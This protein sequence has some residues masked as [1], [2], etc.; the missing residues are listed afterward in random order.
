MHRPTTPR[1][2]P[3]LR[4]QVGLLEFGG[5]RRGSLRPS[6]QLAALARAVPGRPAPVAVRAGGGVRRGAGRQGPHSR[7]ADHHER[8]P[9]PLR[10]DWPPV[11][12]LHSVV[13][14][15]MGL[16]QLGPLR[17]RP[18]YSLRQHSSPV[19]GHRA[20]GRHNGGVRCRARSPQEGRQEPPSRAA[21]RSLAPAECDA[22]PGRD[23]IR[24]DA[25]T[26]SSDWL[27]LRAEP[28]GG[29][30]R[31]DADVLPEHCAAD[32]GGLAA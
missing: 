13:P 14:G 26:L 4:R 32:D 5:V 21:G 12:R 29:H 2:R 17:G 23:A 9:A 3:P 7:Q 25:A 31:T 20:Y 16:Y 18:L 6:R 28:R 24:N 22:T 27:R 11:D 8:A 19:P 30:L 15:R 10:L 1:L